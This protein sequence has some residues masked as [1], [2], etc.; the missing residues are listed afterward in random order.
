MLTSGLNKVTVLGIS[1]K[2]SSDWAG[3]EEED[4]VAAPAA[5][6]NCRATLGPWPVLIECKGSAACS[7][8]GRNI[9]PRGLKRVTTII[10]PEN[11]VNSIFN[12]LLRIHDF[13]GQVEN[14]LWYSLTNQD[15]R[16][17]MTEIVT[18]VLE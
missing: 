1:F 12:K 8:I 13:F 14:M 18:V 4:V 6:L 5:F 3:T 16:Q 10:K 9:G 15:V 2:S 11:S 7:N 17:L